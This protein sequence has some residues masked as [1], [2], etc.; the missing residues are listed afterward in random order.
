MCMCECGVC[1]FDILSSFHN[2]LKT[3][4]IRSLIVNVHLRNLLRI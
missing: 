3:T 4:Y 1:T 2:S